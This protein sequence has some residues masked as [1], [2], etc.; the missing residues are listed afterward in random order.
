MCT[1]VGAARGEAVQ[2]R[3]PRPIPLGVS[4]GSIDDW[5]TR[6]TLTLCC[7]G[8]LGALVQDPGGT[9]YI[10]SNNHIRGTA[11]GGTIGDDI[12][13]PGIIDSCPRVRP[14]N[15]VADL[16]SF[17]LI[18]LDGDNLVDAAIAQ[19][20]PG[21]VNRSG[22]IHDIGTPGPDTLIAYPGLAVKK[23]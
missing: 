12:V 5:S 18:S 13:Q 23:S 17:I 14:A 4:G 16:S 1:T 20:R 7:G 22:L 21:Q 2:A 10:L 19:I 3:T 8:T 6:A 15:V 11:G 9:L